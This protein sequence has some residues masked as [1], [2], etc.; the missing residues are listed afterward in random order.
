MKTEN[1]QLTK[2]TADNGMV[3]TNGESY[4]REIYL[5]ANDK[6][7]LWRE[8]PESEV[9]ADTETEDEPGDDGADAV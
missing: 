1:I 2:L 5:G 3:L 8:I 4:G 7:D 9:P 6:A